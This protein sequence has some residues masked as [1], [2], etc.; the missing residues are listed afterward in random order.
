MP[1]QA[2]NAELAQAGELGEPLPDPEWTPDRFVEQVGII[3]P[4]LG[5]SL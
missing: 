1:T 2:P 3:T 5:S 4:E